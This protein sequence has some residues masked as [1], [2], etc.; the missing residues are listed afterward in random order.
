MRDVLNG[1]LTEDDALLWMVLLHTHQI[2]IRAECVEADWRKHQKDGFVIL[3]AHTR[4]GVASVIAEIWREIKMKRKR[5]SD[6][7]RTRYESW[8]WDYCSRVPYK[9]AESIPD[10]LR[11]RIEEL[12]SL[13][14]GDLRIV[15][16]VPED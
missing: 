12:K 2:H 15:A 6:D 13:L 4:R 1:R 7:H 10:N 5:Q 9:L 14:L 16:V 11:P 8:Y 3:F